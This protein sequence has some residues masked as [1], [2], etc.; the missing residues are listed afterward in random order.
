MENEILKKFILWAESNCWN[1]STFLDSL[2]IWKDNISVS[3]NRGYVNIFPASIKLPSERLK[4]SH[5]V[6]II[7]MNPELAFQ[8]VEENLDEI[9]RR[10]TIPEEMERFRKK[11]K[12][13]CDKILGYAMEKIG[14]SSSLVK[15]QYCDVLAEE[16][17]W[18]TLFLDSK[19]DHISIGLSTICRL[20]RLEPITKEEAFQLVSEAVGKLTETLIC[21][22]QLELV[23]ETIGKN[24]RISLSLGLDEIG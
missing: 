9:I 23:E 13:I 24:E 12:R 1:V 18:F 19:N 22:S 17:G 4:H 14:H 20:G 7:G 8:S 11:Q 10:Y 6:R 3:V 15:N 5:V 21:Q 2:I 16:N